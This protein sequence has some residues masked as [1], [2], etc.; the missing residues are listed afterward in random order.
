MAR[1]RGRGELTA[2]RATSSDGQ[3]K[4]SPTNHRDAPQGLLPKLAEVAFAP[5]DG[6]DQPEIFVQAQCLDWHARAPREA[7]DRHHST[8]AVLSSHFDALLSRV[9]GDAS[10]DVELEPG[11]HWPREQTGAEPSLKI[12][13][14]PIQVQIVETRRRLT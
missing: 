11:P 6:V 1:G 9:P 10:A 12:D 4:C 13:E 7:P 8:S 2:R 3:A 5:P 14:P